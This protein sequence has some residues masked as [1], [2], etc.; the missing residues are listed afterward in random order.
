VGPLLYTFLKLY[1]GPLQSPKSLFLYAFAC[2]YHETRLE[3]HS[4]LD[5]ASVFSQLVCLREGK[6]GCLAGLVERAMFETRRG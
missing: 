6:V 5:I 4:S 3:P 1:H 2:P